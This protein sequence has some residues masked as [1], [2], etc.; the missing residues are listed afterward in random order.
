M[1]EIDPGEALEVQRSAYE[2]NNSMTRPPTVIKR[3]IIIEKYDVQNIIINWY[4]QFANPNG[5]IAY[6]QDL[7]T[8]FSFDASPASIEQALCDLAPLL[9][10]NG[11][12]PEKEY[13]E[14][15]DDL[16]LW[17]EISLVIEAKNKNKESL[18]KKDAGQ[19]L[20]S[21]QWFRNTYPTRKDPVP[22]IVAK[23]VVS[24][25]K[26]SF[27]KNTRV[28]TPENMNNL[29]N[30]LEK[31]YARIISEPLFSSNPK[32]LIKI[33]SSSKISPEQFFS[34]FTVGIQKSKS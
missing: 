34:N 24:D 10:A 16:W 32:T 3:A 11:S 26:S 2:H 28:I 13:G 4:K 15:P 7:K 17:P 12:R 19:L 5:A 25:R 1:H 30:A 29:L 8:R 21:L 9:G 6:I 23:V 31:F 27:P 20:L 18:H 22:I 33:Q 14:G